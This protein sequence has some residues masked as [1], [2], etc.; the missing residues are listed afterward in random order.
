MDCG[1]PVGRAGTD[2]FVALCLLVTFSSF[3]GTWM[4][5][6]CWRVSLEDGLAG[7]QVACA[8]NSSTLEAEV[9]GWPA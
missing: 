3:Y 2:T 8:Y 7:V 4:P 6:V 9:G 5:P 1:S